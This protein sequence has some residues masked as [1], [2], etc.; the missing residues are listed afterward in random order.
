MGCQDDATGLPVLP[1][2]SHRG[3]G[4]DGAERL[5][6]RPDAALPHR[7]GEQQRPSVVRLAGT[8]ACREILRPRPNQDHLQGVG[9][10]EPDRQRR[11]VARRQ[12]PHPVDRTVRLPPLRKHRSGLRHEGPPIS[13]TFLL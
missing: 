10:V 3:A 7:R 4:L 1:V 8:S 11:H 6:G 5:R 13:N 12:R 9:P 2:G